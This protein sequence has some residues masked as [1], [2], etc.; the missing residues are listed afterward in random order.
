MNCDHIRFGVRRVQAQLANKEMVKRS[1]EQ[2]KRS[3]H[4]AINATT[5]FATPHLCRELP[6]HHDC[7]LFDRNFCCCWC[8]SL[9]SPVW[10]KR[11]K[12]N[13]GLPKFNMNGFD[14]ICAGSVET[15]DIFAPRNKIDFENVGLAGHKMFYEC[16]ELGRSNATRIWI[17]FYLLICRRRR[18]VWTVGRLQETMTWPGMPYIS[19]ANCVWDFTKLTRREISSRSIFSGRCLSAILS[20]PCMNSTLTT[21]LKT[22]SIYTWTWVFI[23]LLLLL[24]C[25][26][27][28]DSLYL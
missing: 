11:K 27:F 28:A 6:L 22:H 5:C 26:L 16:F 9:L 2:K 13:S 23:N 7:H 20:P 19:N 8:C 15:T 10:K 3:L 12:P 14:P 1:S 21:A 24:P 17:M 4:I 18:Y 25:V